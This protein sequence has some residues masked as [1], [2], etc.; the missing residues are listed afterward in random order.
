VLFYDT[1][2]RRAGLSRTDDDGAPRRPR[3]QMLR[4]EQRRLS[5]RDRHVEHWPQQRAGTFVGHRTRRHFRLIHDARR[6]QF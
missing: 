4:Q 2:H 5:C 6:L 1:G 3:R